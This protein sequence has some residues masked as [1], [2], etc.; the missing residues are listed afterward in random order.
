MYISI[1]GNT[2]GVYIDP[3]TCRAFVDPKQA[4]NFNIVHDIDHVNGLVIDR[5]DNGAMHIIQA[6]GYS[7]DRGLFCDLY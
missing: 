3:G 7:H 4:D 2:A 6:C 1:T 5:N